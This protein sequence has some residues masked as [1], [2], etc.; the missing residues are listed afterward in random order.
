MQ[1]QL[2]IYV[3]YRAFT[4][5][6]TYIPAECLQR[7]AFTYLYE[8]NASLG[9]LDAESEQNGCTLEYLHFVKCMKARVQ[10]VSVRSTGSSE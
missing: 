8:L 1:H 7:P 6:H 2:L 9:N 4:A 3:L 5:K 10:A